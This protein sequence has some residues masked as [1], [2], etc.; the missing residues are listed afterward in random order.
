M[1]ITPGL[2]AGG[3][4]F[5]L[6]IVVVVQAV[7]Y[8]VGDE[9]LAPISIRACTEDGHAV[10]LAIKY[11]CTGRQAFTIHHR[12]V[13]LFN[14]FP[15]VTVTTS[16]TTSPP[17]DEYK[18]ATLDVY[19][20]STIGPSLTMLTNEVNKG[21]YVPRMAHDDAKAKVANPELDNELEQLAS[22]AFTITKIITRWKHTM[23]Y[24]ECTPLE[25]DDEMPDLVNDLK[26][27]HD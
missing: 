3:I 11:G 5:V 10:R 9:E 8:A 26:D 6:A 1:F 16:A 22:T 15:L 27:K 13:S 17:T 19:F 24:T 18:A 7:S 14:S 4:A 12:F 25:S 2:V 21:F 20:P 23:I